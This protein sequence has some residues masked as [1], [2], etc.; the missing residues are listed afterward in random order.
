[1]KARFTR[2]SGTGDDLHDH[3]GSMVYPGLHRIGIYIGDNDNTELRY[4]LVTMITLTWYIDIGDNNCTELK[5]PLVTMI[6]LI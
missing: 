4:I 2:N 3:H 5:Y 1:M 6:T